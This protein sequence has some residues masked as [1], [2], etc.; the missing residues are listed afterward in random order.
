MHIIDIYASNVYNQVSLLLL[1]KT[2][3]TATTS[4][5]HISAHI[6]DRFRNLW[7][8]RKWDKVI[9]MHSEVETSYTIQCQKAFLKYV[10]NEYCPKHQRISVIKC[11]YLHFSKVFP[12]AKA[13]GFTQSSFDRYELSGDDN[14]DSMPSRCVA[15]TTPGHSDLTACLLTATRFYWQSRPESPK[16]WGQENLNHNEYH[17]SPMVNGSTFW[18]PDNTD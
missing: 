2:P 9:D 16:N 13:S 17:S 6:R 3:N 18:M 11:E 7:L 1:R 8:F 12:S 15:A 10:D 14:Q 4:V 5:L